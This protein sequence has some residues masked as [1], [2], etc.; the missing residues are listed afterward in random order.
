MPTLADLAAE[1][2][3]PAETLAS[4]ADVVQKWDGYFSSADQKIADAQKKLE[5]AQNLQ[6]TIDEQIA[7]FGINESTNI[8]L[9]ANLAAIKAAKETLEQAGVKLDL[10]LPEPTKVD[11]DQDF[12][13]K[14]VQ[15][16]TQMGQAMSVQNRYYQVFG[17]PMPDDPVSLADEAA[18]NR[19]SLSDYAEKK[20]GFSS[21]LQRKQEAEL[22][23]KINAGIEAGVKKYQEEHPSNAG[24][25][26]LNGGL[27]SNFP[28]MPAPRDAK[29]LRS[30]SSMTAREKIQSAME[31]A[32]QAA[33]PAG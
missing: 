22:Q 6:K 26:D 2:G 7:T 16:F 30:F 24:H 5:D 9:Q 20:Y 15:G 29:D 25:P 11:P 8:Q 21:E 13:T 14:V 28:K 23:A 12:R 32:N 33:K 17:K 1:L 27:P 3:I 31:R 4:K 10:K 19:M 18:R